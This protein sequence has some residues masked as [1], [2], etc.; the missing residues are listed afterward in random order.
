[1][2]TISHSTTVGI[3]LGP[4]Y[5]SPVLIDAGVDITNLLSPTVIYTRTSSAASYVIQNGGTISGSRQRRH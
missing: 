4:S 2:T 3:K 1:M 5:T